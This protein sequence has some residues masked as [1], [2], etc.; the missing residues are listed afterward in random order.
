MFLAF[1]I[2]VAAPLPTEG[3]LADPVENEGGG[4]TLVRKSLS[5]FFPLST[6]LDD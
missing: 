6:A 1:G 3:T 2:V 5:F 4:T